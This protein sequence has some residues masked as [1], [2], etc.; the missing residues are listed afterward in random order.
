M[1]D[2]LGRVL[3]GRYRLLAP[4]GMGA[5]AHVYLADDARLRRHVAVKILHAALAGDEGF[6]RRFRAEARAAAGLRHPHIMSVYDW[7]EDEGGPFLVLEHLAGG[8]LRDM[9]DA[10]HLLTPGQAARVGASTAWALDYAHRRGLVHRDVKP[11][12]LLFDD[13][14]R[15]CIADFGLARALAEAAWT[16]PA[17]LVIG[18]ARYASPEQARGSSVDPKA[19]VY[20]LALVL[21]EALTGQAPFAADTTIATLMARLERPLAPPEAAGPLA[22]ALAAAGTID[23]AER[24]DAAGLARRLEEASRQ[25]PVP[26]P[27]ALTPS[28]TVD[29][30]EVDERDRTTHPGTSG[31]AAGTSLYD[32]AADSGFGG[33]DATTAM[34]PVSEPA[35]PLGLGSSFPAEMEVEPRRRSRLRRAALVL[36]ALVLLGAAGAGGVFAYQELTIP[37]HAVPR[38]RTLT[39]AE[40]RAAVSGQDF[41]IQVARRSFDEDIPEGRIVNQDPNEGAALKEGRVVNVVLSKGARP[42]EVP[43]LAGMQQDEAVATLEEAGLVPKLE[44]RFDEEIPAGVVIGW[45]P[46]HDEHPKG[47]EVVVTVSDGPEPR[48]MP[49]L[50]KKSWEEAEA[51]LTELGLVPKRVDDYSRSVKKGLVV[52]TTP[53]AGES[54]DKGA[55]VA[56]VVSQ[57]AKQVQVPD[58]SGLSVEEAEEELNEAGLKVKG[59]QGSTRRSVK[60]TD[61][62]EGKTVEEGSGVTLITQ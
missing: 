18:T 50:T 11:A 31:G 43:T 54:V 30:T 38:L 53:A 3:G 41:S 27:L 61:P 33:G 52:S 34:P 24:I 48:S 46:E 8:S 35:S 56:V 22:P 47:T 26:Q 28:G 32:H 17:G 62:P 14:G 37:S 2:Q 40:A 4:I 59:V 19:D 5:S 23:P 36:I 9:L 10:G 55:E 20:S 51:A 58:V 57:G 44:K 21:S 29:L 7:G 1:A 16:E 13:E 12:N 60:R 25:L 39:L 6:L 15:L 49:D 45:S 42:R